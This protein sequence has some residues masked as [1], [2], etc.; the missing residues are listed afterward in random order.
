MTNRRAATTDVNDL[1]NNHC[2]CFTHSRTCTRT[3]THSLSDF[4]Q[5]GLRH[6]EK[7][8]E[9]GYHLPAVHALSLIVPHLFYGVSSA[10]GGYLAANARFH[11]LLEAMLYYDN[12][13]GGMFYSEYPGPVTS[14]F[15][16]MIQVSGR[17]DNEARKRVVNSSSA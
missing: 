3:C 1:T 15:T 14:H 6:L 16:G 11:K 4:C 7:L 12:S 9:Q 13:K 5:H 17:R 10:G 2:V 8:V